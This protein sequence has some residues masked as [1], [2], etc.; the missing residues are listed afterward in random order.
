MGLGSS[1]TEVGD[2]TFN[3]LLVKV[4]Q[5]ADDNLVEA[6]RYQVVSSLI[7]FKLLNVSK[8]SVL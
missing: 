4:A 8:A 3:H 7:R 5:Q 2:T 1:S 6:S